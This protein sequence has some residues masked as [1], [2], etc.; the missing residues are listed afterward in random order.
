MTDPSPDV[1]RTALQDDPPRD[2]DVDGQRGVESLVH[3]WLARAF[4]KDVA[5]FVAGLALTVHEALQEPPLERPI[6]LGLYAAMMGIPA[7]LTGAT[8]K[9]GQGGNDPQP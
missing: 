2:R 5:L 8:T 9:R 4:Q 7:L 1:T 3:K 6:L